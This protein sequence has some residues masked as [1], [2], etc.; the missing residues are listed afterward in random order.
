MTTTDLGIPGLGGL[1]GVPTTD[2]PQKAK[3]FK[4]DQEVRWCPGCGDYVV[5]NAVQSFLPSLGLKRENIV[6]ISGIGCS[7]R[8]P[9]YMNTYGMHSIHGRAPAIATGLATS[10]PDLSVWVVTGDGDALSIGGNHLIHALRRNVNLKILLFNNRIYGLTKGQYSPTSEVGK[11]T[12]STPV[13]SLDHPFNPVSLA[14][15]AEASFVARVID[16]D[17]ASVTETL[18]AAAEHRGSALVEIYQNCP[19]FNDGAFDVLKDNDEKQRRIVALKHGEPIT[20]GP[21]DEQYGVVSGPDGFRV[22][23]LSEVDEAEVVVHDAH[24]DDPSYAFA[25]SRL[26]GQDLNPAVTGIF[27]S[28]ERPAYD[29]LARAQVAEAQRSRPADLR[30]LLHGNDTWTI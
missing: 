16:S 15:G 27:R 11:V 21:E 14:L 8:F 22:A 28:V 24:R 12:K 4:S 18:K 13:G 6:F 7:S 30:K 10:R 17:R 9:Y 25:L 20:F 19:I 1:A 5:L 29:D 26:G 23:K 3:D 2:E